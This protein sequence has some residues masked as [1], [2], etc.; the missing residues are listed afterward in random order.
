[1]PTLVQTITAFFKNDETTSTLLSSQTMGLNEENS[2]TT[3]TTMPNTVSP[4]NWS[5]NFAA[6]EKCTKTLKVNKNNCAK[7]TNKD[8]QSS[9]CSNF[10]RT[11][12]Y[13]Q[14]D[15]KRKMH[16]IIK[17]LL[18]TPELL[19]PQDIIKFERLSKDIRNNL[20][21]SFSYSW[22]CQSPA[23]RQLLFRDGRR[24]SRSPL[25]HV[26]DSTIH[27]DQKQ[28]S[29]KQQRMQQMK[30]N[31]LDEVLIPETRL[32][33]IH[34]CNSRV[35]STCDAID[36]LQKHPNF[37]DSFRGTS[38]KD[39][40][41]G[42][43]CDLAILPD[44][45]LARLLSLKR[46]SAMTSVITMNVKTI[47]DTKNRLTKLRRDFPDSKNIPYA[48]AFYSADTP[49]STNVLDPERRPKLDQYKG[50]IGY[51]SDLF[52]LRSE[53]EFLRQAVFHNLFGCFVVF[54]NAET[55]QVAWNDCQE[56]GIF[57][58]I[59]IS[60]ISLDTYDDVVLSK[61]P[62]ANYER[63]AEEIKTEEK[64]SD[65]NIPVWVW[66]DSFYD[67]E[68][69][70]DVISDTASKSN[71]NSECISVAKAVR[72]TRPCNPFSVAST[73]NMMTADEKRARLTES[74]K[75]NVCIFSHDTFR[76]SNMT[77]K[78]KAKKRMK[79]LL[80]YRRVLLNVIQ[81]GHMKHPN[82]VPSE[83]LEEI[84]YQDT[85]LSRTG[86]AVCH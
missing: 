39:T 84:L 75:Q 83:I 22:Y 42:L 82:P 62:E 5:L 28:L 53:H 81:G 54:E 50:F 1:M 56:K 4:Q 9:S 15:H 68:N 14:H 8:V 18:E 79:Q 17:S 20:A 66:N 2:Q 77:A 36:Y 30:L 52:I 40:I 11:Q 57:E 45:R 59:N 58:S 80:H 43:L 86:R 70:S 55:C 33:L 67:K 29:R 44:A 31:Y 34:L 13:Q 21:D 38:P 23:K 48:L 46:A 49:L 6:T 64:K 24:V 74:V 65:T 7:L 85:Q 73:S 72:Q 37:F 78:K 32:E 12:R 41:F 26:S 10:Y 69:E 3:I 35:R 19:D 71:S 47:L 61:A 63:K 27:H 76:I 25:T 16:K 51:A 60:F